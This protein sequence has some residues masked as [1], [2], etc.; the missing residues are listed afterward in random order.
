MKQF[1]HPLGVQ[2][3][4]AVEPLLPYQLLD[5]E[6]PLLRRQTEVAVSS[7][8][9]WSQSTERDSIEQ[10]VAVPELEN[11]SDLAEVNGVQDDVG[12][13]REVSLRP[14]LTKIPKNP[15]EQLGRLTHGIVRLGV[16]TIDTDEMG[17]PWEMPERRRPRG[18][19]PVR[20]HDRREFL[21]QLRTDVRLAANEIHKQVAAG[22]HLVEEGH[23]VL[24]VHLVDAIPRPPVAIAIDWTAIT[25]VE[26]EAHFLP[27][28]AP[29]KELCE[30]GHIS[31]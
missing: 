24:V 14:G 3:E 11:L 30:I 13:Y 15:F 22:L 8:S 27:T 1:D 16:R 4:I 19:D 10:A 29:K 25:D 2:Q 20:R 28:H 21:E 6:L 18:R 12:V 26:A 5:N 7:A 31:Y 17:R 23:R 9:D